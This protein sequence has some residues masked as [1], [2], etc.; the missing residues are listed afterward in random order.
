MRRFTHLLLI[1][2]W[3]LATGSQWDALQVFA[4]ARMTADNAQTLSWSAALRRT[5]APGSSC[6]LC[7]TVRDGKQQQE[8]RGIPGDFAKKAPL[9]FQP[10]PQIVV[11]RPAGIPLRPENCD[12]ADLDRAPPPTPPPRTA[13]SV[14]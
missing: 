1:L 12:I 9:V 13:A 5:F 4:W 10:L 3:L 2:S 14:A 8:K 6:E 11:L 7:T